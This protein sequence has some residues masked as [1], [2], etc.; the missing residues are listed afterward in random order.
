MLF[1]VNA[2]PSPY[3]ISSIYIAVEPALST[4]RAVV[5]YRLSHDHS[6]FLAIVDD[7]IAI[8]K[9]NKKAIHNQ[10]IEA[11]F[12]LREII[13]VNDEFIVDGGSRQT[14]TPSLHRAVI[15]AIEEAPGF[16]ADVELSEKAIADLHRRIGIIGDG[17]ASGRMFVDRAFVYERLCAADTGLEMLR[18][19]CGLWT[20]DEEVKYLA[21][22]KALKTLMTYR[23][24][25]T[26]RID[27]ETTQNGGLK[28]KSARSRHPFYV[29]TLSEMH[30]RVLRHLRKHDGE[31]SG[32]QRLK[33]KEFVRSQIHRPMDLAHPLF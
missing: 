31:L 6:L 12:P 28:A 19:V 22:R 26:I 30:M 8:W 21:S 15:S 3:K 10:R 24:G 14:R 11:I 27:V 2:L 32:H 1:P 7:R 18:P 25:G 16:G 5:W 33:F 17:I 13:S 23:F 20:P 9:R 29:G 4:K